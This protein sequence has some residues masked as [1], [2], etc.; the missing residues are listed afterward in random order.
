[1]IAKPD[2]LKVGNLVKV[3]GY[4]GRIL[5]IAESDNSL[6]VKVESAKGARRFQRPDWL[7]YT[8][9]PDLWE[10]ATVQDLLDDAEKEKRAALKSIEAVEKYVNKITT[11][12]ATIR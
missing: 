3:N 9:A 5:E 1:M 8:I 6:M 10:P 7:D 4:V 11:E 2:F 12:T